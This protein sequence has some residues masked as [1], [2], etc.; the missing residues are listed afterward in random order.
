MID[1]RNPEVA[2]A[3][4]QDPGTTGG[5]LDE[6]A[7]M[8]PSMQRRV[9]AHA[10]ADEAL[11]RY[12]TAHGDPV[13]VRIATRRLKS[14]E[15]ATPH[16]SLALPAD[17]Y[18]VPA[19]PGKSVVKRP[20]RSPLQAIAIGA[21][22]AAVGAT[23]VVSVRMYENSLVSDPPPPIGGPVVPGDPPLPAQPD[24]PCQLPGNSWLFSVCGTGDDGFS[25]VAISGN[26]TVFAAGWSDSVDGSFEGLDLQTPSGFIAIVEPGSY[27]WLQ[28]NSTDT[29]AVKSA[30]DGTVVAV[31]TNYFDDSA[32]VGKYDASGNPIWHS[33][34]YPESLDLPRFEGAAVGQDGSIVAWG[35]AE[36]PGGEH[37]QSHLIMAKYTPDGDLLWSNDYGEAYKGIGD[38]EGAVVDADGNI[39][40]VGSATQPKVGDHEFEDAMV[41][42]F[43]SSGQLQWSRTF[44]GSQYDN[45]HAVT[46]APNGNIIA[47]GSSDSPDG[48]FATSSY[49][50]VGVLAEIDQNGNLVSFWTHDLGYG[51]EFYDIAPMPDGGYAIAGYTHDDNMDA[52]VLVVRD[53]A[54]IGDPDFVVLQKTFG[55]NRGDIFY[56]VAV[57][58]NGDIVLAGATDSREGTLL[59]SSGSRDAV[60]IRLTPDG[61]IV[62][63]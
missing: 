53:L 46:T 14:L 43:S 60:V 33:Q 49:E 2:L 7:Q 8:H 55:G 25:S 20:R 50:S 51:S 28:S 47:V 54:A 1:L 61:Q 13:A 63:R 42:K 45:F 34:F 57:D 6:I 40:L 12:L 19:P 38:P 17:Y 62:P 48:V 59:A 32:I 21:L 24:L 31:G 30:P 52:L 56:G 15:A 3:A 16:P 22:V 29:R 18:P 35:Y 41:S 10:N 27:P 26:G 4:L 23:G 44:G 58:S 39:F 37:Y 36:V 11:L 9:A 5:D